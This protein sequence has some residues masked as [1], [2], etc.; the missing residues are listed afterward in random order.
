VE[1][2]QTD[3]NLR[4]FY[5]EITDRYYNEMIQH[6]RETG[7]KIPIAGTN[8]S[9]G[10]AHLLS[11]MAGDF[12]DSHAYWYSWQWQAEQKK[13]LNASM[14]GSSDNML[15]GLA[16][17]RVAGKPFF[18]SE[19][20][21]P[22]PNEW[23]AESSLLLAA[24]GAL[25]GWGGYCIH[26]Y[27]YSTDEKV[28]MI[29][30]PITSDAIG[31]VYYRGGVFDTFNDPAKFGLFYH[32]ALLFRRGD[33][34]PSKDP[35]YIKLNDLAVSPDI[36]ALKLSTEKQRIEIV[37]PEG[38]NKGTVTVSPDLPLVDLEK[39]EILSSTKELYRNLKTKTGWIDTP[40]TKAV[41]GFLG[42][43]GEL[44]LANLKITVKNDFATIAISSLSDDPVKSSPNMLIT[45]VGRA[46]NTNTRYNEDHTVQLCVGNGPVQVEIIEAKI[47]IETTKEKLKV[48]A[49]NP[50]GFTIGEI[51]SEYEN[52]I[53]RF[54]I[55]KKYPSM[56]YLIQNY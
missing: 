10:G 18:V 35:V 28:E 19:W 2:N 42:K 50:Q 14:T 24:V 20:D 53:F 5:V 22:W 23:R 9:R 47:E 13:F 37:L 41:Y 21:D 8:W 3:E 52:G 46:D 33:V 45:A 11:Q 32:A 26:T 49:I 40:N 43:I 44:N 1:F 39:G 15:P 56:Y 38:T 16:F 31:G 27:R 12:T 54:E 25:Q 4:N 48:L 17:N 55:G 30:K 34:D 36:K 51:P 6:M 29:G 7:V